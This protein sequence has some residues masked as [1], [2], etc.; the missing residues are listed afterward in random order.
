MR[1]NLWYFGSSR[2]LTAGYWHFFISFCSVCY[3]IIWY[4]KL[5]APNILKQ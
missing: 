5:S 4:F 1:C 2:K 3:R